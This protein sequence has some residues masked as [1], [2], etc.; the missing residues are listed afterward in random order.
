MSGQGCLIPVRVGTGWNQRSVLG[1][2]V[3]CCAANVGQK[4]QT[5]GRRVFAGALGDQGRV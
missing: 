1:I 2:A 5:L 3:L 4:A